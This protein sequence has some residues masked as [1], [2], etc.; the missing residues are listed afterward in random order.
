LKYLCNKYNDA[1]I[2]AASEA[3]LLLTN[4]EMDAASAAAMWEESNC[5]LCAQRIKLRHLKAFFGRR[6]TVPEHKNWSWARCFQYAIQ[7]NLEN[8]RFISGIKKS[9]MP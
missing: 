2:H 5:P 9:V 4:K 7:L 6:I 3:G 1:F 8:P